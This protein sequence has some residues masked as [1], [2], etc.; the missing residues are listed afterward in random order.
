MFTSLS[1]EN[2]RGFKNLKIDSL[3]QINLI[4]GANSVGK[5]A[6]LEAI[7]LLLGE[8]N[9][10]LVPRVS[11]F[12]GLNVFQ[13]TA[14]NMGEWFWRPLFHQLDTRSAI[15]LRAKNSHTF[16]RALEIVV[17]GQS[18]AQVLF[19]ERAQVAGEKSSGGTL[20]AALQF[21]YSEGSAEPRK[22]KLS[23]NIVNGRPTLQIEPPPLQPSL[24]GHLLGARNTSL[25]EDA[26]LLG[27]LIIQKEPYDLLKALQIVEPRL[28][29]INPIPSPGG[30]IIYGDIG[31]GEMMPL[32]LLGDGL[33]RLASIVLRV[34]AA[35]NGVVLIDE[36]ENGL[37]HS[38]L[39]KVWSAIAEASRISGAQVFATTHNWECIKAAHE[40]FSERDSYNLNLYRLER[41]N[42]EVK[43]AAYNQETLATSV[44]MDLEVR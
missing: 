41:A 3:A 6:L 29:R 27:E 16:E 7:F 26:Q 43:V 35:Q 5:T 30:T 4:A 42:G 14:E 39:V 15:R 33:T 19:G 40:A 25:E 1:I 32:T 9:A 23:V 37:H 24:P 11:A 21:E 8:S 13:G 17:V 12:R 44:K 28:T 10:A 18:S 20:G 31:L 22:S 2:F 34:V 38:A 36:I